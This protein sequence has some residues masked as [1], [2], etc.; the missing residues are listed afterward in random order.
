MTHFAR[1]FVDSIE[2]HSLDIST[3]E[4]SGVRCPLAAV[5]LLSGLFIHS[6]QGARIY[7][8]FNEVFGNALRSIDT[9]KNLSLTD[10]KTAIREYLGKA[11]S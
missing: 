7:Y 10:I 4:L 8:V 11:T 6:F 9:A 3:K 5:Q 2:G 1:D